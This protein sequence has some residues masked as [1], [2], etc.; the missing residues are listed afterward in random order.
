MKPIAHIR[1]QTRTT[2][3]LLLTLQTTP[4]AL[5]RKLHQAPL[6]ARRLAT[7]STLREVF[8]D[9]PEHALHAQNIT[10]IRRHLDRDSDPTVQWVVRHE[11]TGAALL[12]PHEEWAFACNGTTPLREVLSSFPWTEID[13]AGTEIHHL[14]PCFSTVVNRTTWQVKLGDSGHIEVALNIGCAPAADKSIPLCELELTLLEGDPAVLFDT[15]WSIAKTLP[16]LPACTA[17]NDHHLTQ[18]QG[19]PCA[20]WPAR[21]PR[22]HKSMTLPQ[23]AQILLTEMLGQCIANLAL[24]PRSDAPELVH[25]ARVGW[26]RFKSVFR[27]F[28]PVLAIESAPSWEPLAPLMLALGDLRDCDVALSETFPR[29]QDLYTEGKKDLCEDWTQMTQAMERTAQGRRGA[30]RLKLQA[31]AV[32]Q[33]L[34]AILQWLTDLSA[35]SESAATANTPPPSPH[36]WALRRLDHLHR[37]LRTAAQDLGP[38]ESQHRARILAKRLRYGTEALRTWIPKKLGQRWGEEASRL[39]TTLGA[40]RDL[41]RAGALA[42]EAGAD[43]RLVAFL[44]GVAAGHQLHNDLPKIKKH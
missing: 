6:L 26:R 13:P 4:Q 7:H 23:A 44:L 20:P 37:R 43:P 29:I 27:L 18:F 19:R 42:A 25:Q 33:T 11:A 34:L 9:T 8:H 21:P 14:A 1:H 5:L 36:D 31:P 3:R 39:Q 15:A 16:V 40:S 41:A 10:L 12:R 17:A 32:G 28:K 30:V 24:L 35:L 38:L 2:L 22:L